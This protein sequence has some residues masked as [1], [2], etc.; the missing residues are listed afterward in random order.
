MARAEDQ[1][2]DAVGPGADRVLVVVR[3]LDDRVPGAELA[4]R[5]VLPEKA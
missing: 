1:V 5:F 2:V 3:E 4:D